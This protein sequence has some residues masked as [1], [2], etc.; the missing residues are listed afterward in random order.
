MRILF[1]SIPSPGHFYPLVPLAWAMRSAR[2]EVL[3]AT[4]DDFRSEVLASGLPVVACSGPLDS[5]TILVNM[6][7]TPWDPDQF[8][9]G[10]QEG[11]AEPGFG[12]LVTALLPGTLALVRDW[13]PDLVVIEPA[14]RAAELSAAKHGIPLAVHTWGMLVPKEIIPAANAARQFIGPVERSLGLTAVPEPAVIIDTCPPTFQFPGSLSVQNMRYVPYSRA[15]ALPDWGWQ[16]RRRRRACITLGTL[17]PLAVDT[18]ALLAA[19]IA[20][21]AGHGMEVVIAGTDDAL[22]ARAATAA[23]HELLATGWFP[24]ESAL[25]SSDLLIHHGSSGCTMTALACGVPQVAMPQFG[26]H[27]INADRIEAVGIGRRV[28]PG[29]PPNALT[30][31]VGAVIEDP[32]IQERAQALAAEAARQ[33]SPAAVT[34]MLEERTGKQYAGKD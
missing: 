31:A 33:P 28:L 30:D 14:A 34:A 2:H 17:I 13:R 4:S 12:T 10:E 29:S 27:F 26:D 21:A 16:P 11:T 23:G 1:A 32:A 15:T 6:L 8:R 19:A 18:Q 7:R 22:A 3:V 24:L 20:A 25:R 5:A 9:Q